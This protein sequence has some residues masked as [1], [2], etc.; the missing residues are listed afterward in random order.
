[1][2]RYIFIVVTV[3]LLVV[4]PMSTTASSSVSTNF[5]QALENH[6]QLNNSYY[7]EG[8]FT[9]LDSLTMNG[10]I[11]KTS[12]EEVTEYEGNFTVAFVEFQEKRDGF[13]Y[14]TKTELHIWD[15]ENEEF[16]SLSNISKNEHAKNFFASYA[17]ALQKEMQPGSLLL[18][19]IMLAIVILTPVSLMLFVTPSWSTYTT[20]FYRRI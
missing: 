5:V 17:T 2:K 8:S 13:I 12:G 11:S 3:L 7:D 1:M 19:M 14:F 9:V 20:S 16:L 10:T 15:N 4:L 6:L 18:F